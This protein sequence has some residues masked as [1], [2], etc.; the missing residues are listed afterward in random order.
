[1]PHEAEVTSLNLPFSLPLGPKNSHMRR[2]KKDICERKT[3]KHGIA[4]S[5]Q[6]R[7]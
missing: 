3:V 7:H 2:V 5:T 4:D 1:M 6:A